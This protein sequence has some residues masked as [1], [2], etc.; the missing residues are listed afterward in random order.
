MTGIITCSCLCNGLGGSQIHLRCQQ[1]WLYQNP[2][3]IS[4]FW[5]CKECAL[6]A[7]VPD[8]MGKYHCFPLGNAFF[9]SLIKDLFYLFCL[10][11]SCACVHVEISRY[12]SM[13]KHRPWRGTRGEHIGHLCFS[14]M[15]HPKLLGCFSRKALTE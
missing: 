10:L 5:M 13:Y 12:H 11:C 8:E 9:Y 15:G 3:S 2:H 7:P 14:V 1:A 4:Q 6:R